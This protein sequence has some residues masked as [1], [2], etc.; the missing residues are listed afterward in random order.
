[1]IGV[2]AGAVVSLIMFAQDPIDPTLIVDMPI[3]VGAG[4]AAGA[5]AGFLVYLT[6][7]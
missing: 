4:A 7:R 1:M 5:L 2:A 6:R 3:A